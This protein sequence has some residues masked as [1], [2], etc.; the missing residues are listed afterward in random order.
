[1]EAIWA[2]KVEN[3]SLFSSTESIALSKKKEK[4]RG[5]GKKEKIKKNLRSLGFYK[6][7]DCMTGFWK[8]TNSS[9][10]KDIF[11]CYFVGICEHDT[12]EPSSR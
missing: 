9:L 2:L 11:L 7:F 10:S 4:K 8:F 12:Q 6:V 3:W 5:D 1:M